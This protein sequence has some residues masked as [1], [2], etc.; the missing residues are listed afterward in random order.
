MYTTCSELG[1]FMYW[2]FNSMNNL[3]SYYGLV[4]ARIS[5]SEKDLP[6]YELYFFYIRIVDWYTLN[7]KPKNPTAEDIGKIMINRLYF[8]KPCSNSK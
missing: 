7:Q 2:T 5:A 8:L 3:L 4:D 6:L 1:I